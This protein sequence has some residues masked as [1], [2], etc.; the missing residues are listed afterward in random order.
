[1]S[2]FIGNIS[3]LVSKNDLLEAFLTFGRCE[4]EYFKRFA[5]CN[6]ENSSDAAEAMKMWNGKE[7]KGTCVKVEFSQRKSS[8]KVKRSRS[9]SPELGE[10]EKKGLKG[11]IWGKE[12]RALEEKTSESG[13]AG[14][15]IEVNVIC[16]EGR[17]DTFDISEE[18]LQV[19]GGN[20]LN[21]EKDL[22][23]PPNSPNFEEVIKETAGQN[24]TPTPVK[25]TAK[26]VSTPEAS[27]SHTSTPKIANI[28][29][30]SKKSSESEKKNECKY[31]DDNTIV[32]EDTEFTVVKKLKKAGGTT[33]RCGTCQRVLKI[34][35]IQGHLKSKVHLSTHL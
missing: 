12:Q 11:K 14:E 2:L 25:S 34:K 20:R 18:K 31:I 33:V 32:C 5:F 28:V 30:S 23:T 35:S 29:Y 17:N 6:F 13:R 27:K 7:F 24:L 26:G 16:E 19:S 8:N 4:I 10:Q 3:E 22:R 21:L 15:K 1:M 9:N